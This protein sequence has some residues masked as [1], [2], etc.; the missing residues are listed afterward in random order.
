MRCGR[1]EFENMPGRSTCLK[2]GSIL[3]QKADAVEVDP[4][5]MARWKRPLR[6]TFRW[7]RAFHVIPSGGISIPIPPWLSRFSREG[8][9]G[10]LLSVIPGLAHLLQGRLREIRWYILAWFLSLVLAL[11]FYGSFW[12]LCFFGFAIGLHGWIAIHSALIKQVTDFGHRAFALALVSLGVLVVYRN[13]GGLTFRNLA[14][15]YSS[16]AV[17]YHRIETGDYLLASRSRL[18]SEPLTRGALVLA[19]LEDTRHGFWTWS[20]RRRDMGIVQIV[21][22][23]GEKLK[24]KGGAFW[25]NDEQLDAEKYPLPTWLHRMT[26]SVT[27]PKGSYFISAEYNVEVHGRLLNNLDV[28]NICLVGPDSFEAKA[29]MRWMPLMRRGFIR[30]TE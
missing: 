28:T 18:R 10:I 14:G 29:F 21:G 9:F 6:C 13:I 19:S 17:P 22:L 5:R 30:D 1:C 15:G 11:F 25:I 24:I 27:I 26:M 23:P 2:C 3:A 16:V 7:L 4:P 8:L 20:Q 12:G